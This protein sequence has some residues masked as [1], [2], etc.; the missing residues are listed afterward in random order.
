MIETYR[1]AVY[2]WHCDQMGHMNV[3]FYVAKFDEATWAL[4]GAIGV[5]PSYVRQSGCG[6]AGV[7][8]NITY[9]REL[10]AGSLVEIRSHLVTIA[11][12][13]VVFV[14]EMHETE[15]DELCATCELTAVHIDRESRRARA[16]PLS[17]LELARTFLSK[18]S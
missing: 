10:F 11:E 6:M 4:M 15:S 14:H 12:R 8:Q 9:K 13:K 16:F 3:M 18:V 5:T 2:P 7:Q 17:V 1:G